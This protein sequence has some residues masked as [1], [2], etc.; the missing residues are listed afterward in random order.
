MDH[1]FRD[2][3]RRLGP[4]AGRLGIVALGIVLLQS[5]LYG[6]SLLGRKVLLPLDLLAQPH[7]YLPPTPEQP[8]PI[9]HNLIRSDLIYI[10]EPGRQF[11][12]AELH[13]GRWPCWMPYEFAGVP[14]LGA[15]FSVFW[16]LGCSVQ[17]PA[18]LPWV[19]MAI[20]LLAGFGIYAFARSVL[21]V[22]YWPAAV[23]AWCYPLTGFFIFWQGYGLATGAAWLPWLLLAVDKTVRQSSRWGGPGLAL[24]TGLVIA[25]GRLDIAGQV[26]ITSGIYALWCFF[27]QYGKQWLSRRAIGSLAVTAAAWALGFLLVAGQMLPTWEY[28]RTG[29]RVKRRTAGE[30][31]RPPVGLS[32][33]PQIVLPDVYG[34]TQVGSLFFAEREGNQLESAA[35]TYVGLLATLLVAPLA[36]CSRRH[37]SINLL[38]LW[39][40]I[41]ALAWVLNLTGLVSVLRLPLLNMMSHNRFVFVASFAL[42][43]MT[44]EGLDVLAACTLPRRPWFWCAAALVAALLVWCAYRTV[45][46][47][48]PWATQLGN[49]VLRGQAYGW[50]DSIARVRWVQKTFVEV[51]AV[52]TLFCALTLAGWLLL[53]FQSRLRPWYVPALGLLMVADLLWFGFGRS[54]QGDWSLYYPRIPI[55]ERVAQEAEKTSARVLG[56]QCFPAALSVT[57]RLRDVRGYDGV[58]PARLMDLMLLT[59]DPRLSPRIPYALTQWLVPKMDVHLPDVV[60]L[61][62]ILDML[63]VRYIIFRGTPPPQLHVDLA[64]DDY[65]VLENKRALPRVFVPG[66]VETIADE[67]T[68]LRRMASGDFDPRQVAFA[69]TPLDLPEACRGSANIVDEIPT[70]ITVS[71]DLQTPGLVVLA[72]LYSAGWKAYL[73]DQPVPIL[74]VNHAIRGVVAPAGKETLEFRYEP[75]SLAWG[76]RLSAAGLLATLGW[77]GINFWRSRVETPIVA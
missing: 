40:L 50:I 77:L 24:V 34:S 69:E 62:P 47:P 76:L 12:A 20:A 27:D 72:D 35:A 25:E 1:R 51:Y 14:I 8:A 56:F 65:W 38:W 53:G 48:E 28:T 43:A 39:L 68:R 29:A 64:G 70:R 67:Q 9:P 32:A 17:S 54:Y 60:Q 10:G 7:I 36:W 46:L 63:G 23:V 18:V 15:K 45:V 6:P 33:L 13:A 3:L 19:E 21:G 31:E 16:W 74:R 57:H 59:D 41:L 58:D 52:A 55:L 37:R 30:E 5:V 4:P 26:L 61:S 22:R 11:N 66:R 44:A 49:A 2:F 73:N 75:A 71:V 42:M